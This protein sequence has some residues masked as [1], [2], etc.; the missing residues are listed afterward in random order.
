MLLTLTLALACSEKPGG[1]DSVAP[2]TSA[3]GETDEP[4]E[5]GAPADT[6][7]ETGAPTAGPVLSFEAPPRNLL[8]IALDTTRR[9]AIGRWSGDPEATPTLDAL[10]SESVVL[11]DHR[12]CS[13]WTW[14]SVLCVQTG[15]N[16]W[17]LGFPYVDESGIALS[18]IP[19]DVTLMSSVMSA[20]GYQTGLASAQSFMSIENRMSQGFDD[21][22]YDLDAPAAAL[23]DGALA[24]LEDFDAGAPWYL[25]L[26]Y[27]DPHEL[28]IPPESYLGGLEAL[29][30]IDYDLTSRSEY[31]ELRNGAIS[32]MSDAERELVLAHLRVRYAAELRYFDDQ[33]SRLIDAMD[34]GGW[35]DDTLVV[36]WTDH[37]EQ[38]WQ[39]G[40]STHGGS[41]YD[42]ETRSTASFWA[43]GLTPSEWT[44]PTT[45]IDL[46]PTIA[47]A[48]SVP[49][50]PEFTGVPL[51]E[52][53]A[54]AA[55]FSLRYRG[56]KTFHSVVRDQKKLFYNW[57]GSKEYYDL[58]ADPGE[59]TDAYD[60]TAADIIALWELLLPQVEAVSEAMAGAAPV[61][62][63]P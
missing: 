35:L 47:E 11:A 18:S 31:E 59:L 6:S 61:E 14:D 60:S 26:H 27:M 53:G 4:G 54:D 62:P 15:R 42:E 41:L 12:S 1:D 45:H 22:W 32:T 58:A 21:T 43:R 50:A 8:I 5:T 51:G 20:A 63:G 48:M 33:L 17:E 40:Y 44:S 37:G 34:A 36:F 24:L 2:T 3:P 7:D 9:D 10:M 23:T 30:P 49:D 19:S 39:H 13:N 55:I 52:R 25:H 29:D 57:N 16:P 28:Y 38:I 56:P 46:W